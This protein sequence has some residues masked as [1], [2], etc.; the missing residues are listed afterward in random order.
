MT[1]FGATAPLS[2]RLT[3]RWRTLLRLP[4]TPAVQASAT[5]DGPPGEET[6]RDLH[7]PPGWSDGDWL[8]PRRD[9]SPDEEA[10]VIARHPLGQPADM[11]VTAVAAEYLRLVEQV[12]W[13]AAPCATC[14]YRRWDD[15]ELQPG[16]YVC[17][18]A[19]EEVSS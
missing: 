16:D 1:T 19:P 10:R 12:G 15:G 3:A 11:P 7:R 14:G 9:P 2:Y 18:C 13:P 8:K 6:T 17:T 5:A 4:A